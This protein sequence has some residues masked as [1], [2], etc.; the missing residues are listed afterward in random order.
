MCR[1]E[2]QRLESEGLRSQ[3]I[4]SNYKKICSDLSYRLDNQQESFKTQKKQIAV[5]CYLDLL[6]IVATMKFSCY[7]ENISMGSVVVCDASFTPI[8]SWFESPVVVNWY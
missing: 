2:V 7:F 6:I 5:S 8:G 3:S 1:R 4:I